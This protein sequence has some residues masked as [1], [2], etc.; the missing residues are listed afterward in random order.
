MMPGDAWRDPG[1]YARLRGIDRAGL[2]WEW[3]RR[4]PA[5]IAWHAQASAATRGAAAANPAVEDPHLWGVHF[6]RESGG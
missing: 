3:L 2:M 6:R 1:S 5:Y 4:D